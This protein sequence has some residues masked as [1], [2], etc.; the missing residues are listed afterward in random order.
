MGLSIINIV[1]FLVTS[2]DSGALVTAMMTSSN[3][4]ASQHRDP[5]IITSSVWTL[6]LGLIAIIILMG[7]G[8][9]ALQIS[10]IVTALPFAK[11]V[12]VAARNLY[13]QLKIDYTKI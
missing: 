7:G 12:V 10:A 2:S 4:A 11:I 1:T 3:H 9:T 5:A 8:L 6:T 13:R